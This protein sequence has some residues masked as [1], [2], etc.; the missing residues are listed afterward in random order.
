VDR[1]VSRAKLF[2]RPDFWKDEAVLRAG[3]RAFA[4]DGLRRCD[5]DLLDRQFFVA[6]DFEHLDG[7]EAVD[8]NVLCDFGHVTTVRGLMKDNVDVLQRGCYARAVLDISLNELSS[9]W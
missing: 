7:A 1:K 4:V 2:G 5:D 3:C 6:D 8:V 9:V